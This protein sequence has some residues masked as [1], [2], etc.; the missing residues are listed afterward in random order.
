MWVLCNFVSGSGSTK[1]KPTLLKGSPGSVACV[2]VLEF[3]GWEWLS[4]H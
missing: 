2:S 4:W 1:S 3:T